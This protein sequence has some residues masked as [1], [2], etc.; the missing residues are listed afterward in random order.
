MGNIPIY[1]LKRWTEIQHFLEVKKL[2][3]IVSVQKKRTSDSNFEGKDFSKNLRWRNGIHLSQNIFFFH[4][5][6][7]CLCCLKDGGEHNQE[8]GINHVPHA[9][10]KVVYSF[11]C[12]VCKV[13]YSLI[14]DCT[15]F[16]CQVRQEEVCFCYHLH[17]RQDSLRQRKRLN[18]QNLAN[19]LGRQVDRVP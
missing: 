19:I 1:L 14:A 15:S 6:E 17:R 3:F 5:Q 8:R 16:Q 2:G 18:R 7:P 11:F 10:E 13:L 9:T 4:L 12:T